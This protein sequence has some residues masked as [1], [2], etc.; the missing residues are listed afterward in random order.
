M[1][2]VDNVPL[3][4]SVIVGNTRLMTELLK[5]PVP[6]I[7]GEQRRRLSIVAVKLPVPLHATN[8]VAAAD[9]AI[10]RNRLT[11]WGCKSLA[12]RLRMV[13]RARG[14]LVKSK[15]CGSS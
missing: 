11:P 9:V 2:E 8:N 4:V 1:I 5:V 13:M 3:P 15:S 14:M 7:D 10:K 12:D 6:V